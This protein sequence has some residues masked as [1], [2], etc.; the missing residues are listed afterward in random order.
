MGNKYYAKMRS[1][2]FIKKCGEFILLICLV[3]V[4][5]K[6]ENYRNPDFLPNTQIDDMMK[7][8]QTPQGTVEVS[9]KEYMD[10]KSYYY[11]IPIEKDD[12][13]INYY[14]KE[15]IPKGWQYRGPGTEGG[16]VFTNSEFRFSLR[17]KLGTIQDK[18]YNWR[19]DLLPLR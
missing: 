16:D 12:E 5:F 4:F 18:D 2:Q 3:F 15:L 9:S 11:S 1:K 14:K 17:K 6:I 7:D 8:I 13:I 10:G 19:I